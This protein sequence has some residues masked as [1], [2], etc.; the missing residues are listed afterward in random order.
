MSLLLTSIDVSANLTAYVRTEISNVL[1]SVRFPLHACRHSK[2]GPE[3]CS[4]P[5]TSVEDTPSLAGA[6]SDSLG[7]SLQSVSAMGDETLVLYHQTSLQNAQAILSSGGIMKRG[8][9]G[10]GGCGIYFAVDPEVSTLCC[11][12]EIDLL[13]YTKCMHSLQTCS[14]IHS[15]SLFRC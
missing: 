3:D 7:C 15:L 6:S 5:A 14:S 8:P 4:N 13:L 1:L 11:C 9:K 10:F 12:A 2:Q